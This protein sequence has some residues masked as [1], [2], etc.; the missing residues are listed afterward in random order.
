MLLNSINRISLSSDLK[1]RE[2]INPTLLLAGS[3]AL[4]YAVRS[5][6]IDIAFGPALECLWLD[7]VACAAATLLSQIAYHD[8]PE[9]LRL[10]ARGIGMVVLIQMAFDGSTLFYA[11][12]SMTT[13]SE[14][15]FYRFGTLLALAAGLGA[16]WRP[17][18]LLPLMIHYVAFRHQLNVL[19]TID[20]SETDYLSMLDVG[21]FCALGGLTVALG[22]KG[23]DDKL[24]QS[25]AGLIWAWAVGAHL[26][27]YLVSAWTK[28]RVGGDDPL[29]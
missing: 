19:T 1:S 22:T 20:I 29:F 13:G 21:E 25:A 5:L 6:V 2:T 17:A 8:I 9:P 24:R 7:V 11:P 27:N 28:I 26:G 10:L 12:A 15:I 23:Q 4:Y 16:I 14:G 18:F 3:L